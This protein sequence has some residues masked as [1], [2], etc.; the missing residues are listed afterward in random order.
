MMFSV[1][2]Q[3]VLLSKP[4]G[5]MRKTAA[6]NIKTLLCKAKVYRLG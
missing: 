3:E 4:A 2:E 1:Y 6:I 5:F